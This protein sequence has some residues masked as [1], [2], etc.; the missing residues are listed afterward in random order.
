MENRENNYKKSFANLFSSS[1]RHKYTCNTQLYAHCTQTL[2]PD[3]NKMQKIFYS[4]FLLPK[5][6]GRSSS[7]EPDRQFSYSILQIS[8][9]KYQLDWAKIFLNNL[10]Q[11]THDITLIL[12]SEFG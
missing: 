4:F 1:L 7:A 5:S 2:R 12:L 8:L 11:M 6:Q 9:E 3:C 10:L